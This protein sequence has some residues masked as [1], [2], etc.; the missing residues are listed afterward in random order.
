MFDSIKI[1]SK[2]TLLIIKVNILVDKKTLSKKLSNWL[3]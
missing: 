1:E 3:F 2:G